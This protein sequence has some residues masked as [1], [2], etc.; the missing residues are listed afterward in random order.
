MRWIHEHTV[1][2]T[3]CDMSTSH[4]Y[5]ALNERVLKLDVI[6]ERLHGVHMP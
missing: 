2:K 6:V 1:Q 3:A 5:G 4:I